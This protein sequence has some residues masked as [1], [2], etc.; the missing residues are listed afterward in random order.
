MKITYH[1][2]ILAQNLKQPFKVLK[3][4]TGDGL[5]YKTRTVRPVHDTL[6]KLVSRTFLI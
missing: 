1:E 6:T 2:T 4:N 5:N 3:M